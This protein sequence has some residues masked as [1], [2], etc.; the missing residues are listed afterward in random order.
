[1][2]MYIHLTPILHLPS[3]LKSTES[4]FYVNYVILNIENNRTIYK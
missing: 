4:K 1:M 3:K 2:A